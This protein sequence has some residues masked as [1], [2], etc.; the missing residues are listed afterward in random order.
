M[1][2]YLVLW[3]GNTAHVKP[4]EPRKLGCIINDLVIVGN[5]Y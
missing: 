2:T 5:D 3:V 1:E 4:G